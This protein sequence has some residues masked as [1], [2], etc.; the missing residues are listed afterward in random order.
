VESE[1][2]SIYVNFRQR[3]L[4]YALD[5]ISGDNSSHRLLPHFIFGDFN[6]RLNGRSVV[7]ALDVEL[8]FR[9]DVDENDENSGDRNGEIV[10][11]S[12]G[13]LM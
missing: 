9:N 6:F 3:A 12:G 2:P 13:R 8:R 10:R 5:N 1:G 4:T 11:Y 7:D